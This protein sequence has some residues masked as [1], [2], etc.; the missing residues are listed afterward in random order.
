MTAVQLEV[1]SRILE[2]ITWNHS[3]PIRA[4]IEWE[5]HFRNG[6]LRLLVSLHSLTTNVDKRQASNYAGKVIGHLIADRSIDFE[7][8]SGSEAV[9]VK[10][11]YRFTYRHRA[12]RNEIVFDAI[13]LKEVQNA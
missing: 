5:T 10:R 6:N 9:S 4:Q 11:S 2:A 7:L 12:K 3:F 13:N 1:W 8:S